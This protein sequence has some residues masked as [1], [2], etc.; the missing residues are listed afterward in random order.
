MG[1]DIVTWKESMV[2]ALLGRSLAVIQTLHHAYLVDGSIY[3]DAQFLCLM[4]AALSRHL[5]SM[6]LE[7]KDYLELE[8]IMLNITKE[9]QNFGGSSIRKQVSARLTDKLL[10]KLFFF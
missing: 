8:S 1:I 4:H 6:R 9:I 2:F 10:Q 5:M 7:Q 3:W